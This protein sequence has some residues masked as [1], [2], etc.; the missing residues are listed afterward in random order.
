MM[1]LFFFQSFLPHSQRSAPSNRLPQRTAKPPFSRLEAFVCCFEEKRKANSR[2]PSFSSFARC[3]SSSPSLRFA[4]IRFVS[5]PRLSLSLFLSLS[6]QTHPPNQPPQKQTITLSSADQEQFEVTQKVACMSKTVENMI[7]GKKKRR[8]EG[9]EREKEEKRE[10]RQRQS[11]D[12]DE[13]KKQ[14]KLTLFSPLS[15]S[16]S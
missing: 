14:K 16:L 1:M 3:R 12:D 9:E 8:E 13:N 7:K 4:S 2:P 5:P 11:A 6:L 10:S 15:F